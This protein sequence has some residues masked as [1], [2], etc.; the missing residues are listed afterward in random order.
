MDEQGT[1]NFA[2]GCML[3]ELSGQVFPLTQDEHE[4]IQEEDRQFLAEYEARKA[5]MSRE[6]E[7]GTKPLYDA[8]LQEV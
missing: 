2:L 5:E 4:R 8:I 6:Q 3:G 1:I 7:R